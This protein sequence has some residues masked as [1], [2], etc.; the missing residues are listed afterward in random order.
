MGNWEERIRFYQNIRIPFTIIV[1]V[2]LLACF[3][4]Y[5]NGNAFMWLID[6]LR[7]FYGQEL[8]NVSSLY[9]FGL[10]FANNSV[11]SFLIIPLGI[12]IAIPPLIFIFFNGFLIG[13]LGYSLSEMYEKGLT[14]LFVGTFPHG[15]I[16]LTAVFWSSA[17]GLRVGWAAINKLRS[18]HKS[19]VKLEIITGMRTFAV[20]ILPLLLLAAFIEAF[21]TPSIISL[22]GFSL[23]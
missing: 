5:L 4:G 11:K 15:V 8:A 12:L 23:T 7:E 3:L 21:I 20:K 22:T 17:I 13:V 18:V 14:F 1:V 16:E 2:F 10:I 9:L 19:S 6:L